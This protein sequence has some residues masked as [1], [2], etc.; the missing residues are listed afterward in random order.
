[1]PEMIFHPADLG[2]SDTFLPFF[3][4]SKYLNF[5]YLLLVELNAS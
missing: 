2:L 3:F 5:G 1:M 4:S